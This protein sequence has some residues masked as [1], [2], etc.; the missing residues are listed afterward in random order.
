MGHLISAGTGMNR[1]KGLAVEDPEV[2]D[3]LILDALEQL[4]SLAA[5]PLD[6][7]ELESE[8]ETSAE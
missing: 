7:L 1:F 2:E 8:A 6:D 5:A 4:E 3:D